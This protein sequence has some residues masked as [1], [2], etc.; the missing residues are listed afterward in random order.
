M[1]RFQEEH[2]LNDLRK[3][4]VF[5]C[6]PR[7]VG[8]T[9]LAK[10]IAAS[11]SNPQYLNYDRLE[12]REIIRREGWPAKTDLLLLD[13][14]HKM[15]GWKN[16]IKGIYD[17]RED[18]L[19]ILVTGSARL[20]MLRQVGDSLAGRY[21]RHRLLPFS[22]SELAQTKQVEYLDIERLIKR[23]G[24]PEPFIADDP[25]D[26]HRWRMQYID[27]L[28]RSDVLDFER[29]HDFRAIQIVLELL[30][31]RVGSPVSYMS[32]A[33][34]AQIA[35]ATVKKYIEIFEG[36]YIVFRV[37]PW[38]RNIARSLL[39]E[40][41]IYFY[42][43]AMVEGDEGAHF[44]NLIACSLLKH[45]CALIDYKAQKW[46]LHYLRTRDGQEVDFCLVRDDRAE[47]MIEAKYSFRDVPRSLIKFNR[48]Y[49][50]PA[51]VVAQNL[52]REQEIENISICKAQ[53]YLSQLFL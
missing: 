39:K 21:F 44:E 48:T 12:D 1:K 43:T 24:F 15:P 29:I 23:G 34:D 17:T 30:R 6:G 20:E 7:Q 16:Y 41:K 46:R 37:T 45:V 13:E 33:E 25:V 40:P 47:L 31:R 10:K 3:K 14:I 50:I 51:M 22:L 38:S 26:S 8:K 18:D 11:Y 35:P 28:I 42:D 19:H 36:L 4:M 5:L 53:K 52:K 2:I 27:G 32:I 9:W 49:S